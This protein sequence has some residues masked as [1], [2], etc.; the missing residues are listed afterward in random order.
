MSLRPVAR[1]DINQ[2]TGADAA[3]KQPALATL[4]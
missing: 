1:E 3:K 2:S 4:K